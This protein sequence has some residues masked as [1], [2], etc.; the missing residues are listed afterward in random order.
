MSRFVHFLS[1]TTS[2]QNKVVWAENLISLVSRRSANN[3]DAAIIQEQ[4][5]ITCFRIHFRISNH[6][7]QDLSSNILLRI[8]GGRKSELVMVIFC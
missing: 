2:N 3:F 1:T 5:Q 8:I 7:S 4:Y 6:L